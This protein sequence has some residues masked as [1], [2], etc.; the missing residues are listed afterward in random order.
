MSSLYYGLN[1][2]DRLQL[3]LTSK[4]NTCNLLSQDAIKLT[5][6]PVQTIKEALICN[7]PDIKHK[8]LQQ[9]QSYTS[10]FIYQVII[11]AITDINIEDFNEALDATKDVD[12]PHTLRNDIIE[13]FKEMHADDASKIINRVKCNIN[14]GIY[15]PFETIRA[16]LICKTINNKQLS[17]L[18]EEYNLNIIIAI[19]N[20]TIDDFNA[21]LSETADYGNTVLRN[22]IVNEY[23]KIP[24]LYSSLVHNNPVT[25]YEKLKRGLSKVGETVYSLFP[26]SKSAGTGK[27][28][29]KSR[30]YIKNIR[31]TNRRRNKTKAR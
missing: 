6:S 5:K 13:K 11:N 7:N 24:N 18:S 2:R 3:Q 20:I 22:D 4:I 19:R 29:K 30:K 1:E 16:A 26:T 25:G 31:K 21:A 12:E 28:G 14:Q 8:T 15:S 23:K 27:G 17:K 9:I 10:K